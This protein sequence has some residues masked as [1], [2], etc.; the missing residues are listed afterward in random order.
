MGKLDTVAVFADCDMTSHQALYRKAGTII[1]KN[2]G[3]LC[4]VARDGQWP[5]ALVD[6]ALAA[7][8]RVTVFSAHQ[9]GTLGVPQGVSVQLAQTAHEAGVLAV[10]HA[11]AVIGLPAGIETA[12]ALYRAWSQAG[13]T[14]DRRPVGLLNHAKAYEIVRGFMA[15]VASVGRGNV[16]TMIQFSETFEDLW[17]RLTRLA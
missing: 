1:A 9:G 12:A 17:N 3:H 10:G 5:R 15:D 8:G 6:S 16:D 4:C 14:T 13:N 11:Q 2:G 7:G